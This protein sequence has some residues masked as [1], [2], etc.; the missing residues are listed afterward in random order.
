MK[1]IGSEHKRL[2]ERKEKTFLSGT[3]TESN[4]RILYLRCRKKFDAAEMASRLG[5]QKYIWTVRAWVSVRVRVREHVSERER[6]CACVCERERERERESLYREEEKHI[7]GLILKG[8][9]HTRS[10]VSDEMPQQ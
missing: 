10:L 9:S 7:S 8:E 6:A 5:A 4:R 1:N 2:E 3:E